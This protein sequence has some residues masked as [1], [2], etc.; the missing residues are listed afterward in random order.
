MRSRAELLSAHD[1]EA[2]SRFDFD[3]LEKWRRGDSNISTFVL[4]LIGYTRSSQKLGPRFARSSGGGLELSRGSPR[5]RCRRWGTSVKG[6][7]E[8]GQRV[9]CAGNVVYFVPR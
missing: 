7:T 9:N 1:G 6:A 2:P 8:G 4:K 5:G 3:G